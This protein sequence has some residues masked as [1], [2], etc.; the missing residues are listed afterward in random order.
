[1]SAWYV[2]SA[3]GF[4]PVN[5]S[6][7]KYQ[8]GSPLVTEAKIEVSSGK[9]F[10]MKASQASLTNKYIQEVQLNGKVLTRNFITHEEITSG[11]LLE[12]KMGAVHKKK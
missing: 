10:T 8:F 4:Y 6:D 2:F 11:G 7:L 9:Y 3:M 5:P 1:M 12:F